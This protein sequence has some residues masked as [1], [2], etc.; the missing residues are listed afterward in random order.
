M[1]ETV[2]AINHSEHCRTSIQVKARH[3]MA[4]EKATKKL[5]IVEDLV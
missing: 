4:V 2:I 3:V 5:I 1:K